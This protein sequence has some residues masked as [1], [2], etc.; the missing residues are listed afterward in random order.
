METDNI[1]ALVESIGQLVLMQNEDNDLKAAELYRAMFATAIFPKAFQ[2]L[3]YEFILSHFQSSVR[4][5]RFPCL[6]LLH[7]ICFSSYIP[8]V[9]LSPDR[10][11]Q[12]NLPGNL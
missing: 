1:D 5:L 10:K 9:L 11:R 4:F 2:F 7:R 6:L 8:T 3:F 12:R